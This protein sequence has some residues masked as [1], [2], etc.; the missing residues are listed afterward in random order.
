MALDQEA[1]EE[2]GSPSM[3]D[4]LRGEYHLLVGR[5]IAKIEVSEGEDQLRFTL[6]D[7]EH[8][9]WITGGTCCSESWF[10]DL[11]G[12]EALLRGTVTSVEKLE[13]EEVDDDRTRQKHD[14]VY[15]F[16]VT[17]NKGRASIAFRNSS[18]GWYCG[19]MDEEAGVG[20][21]DITWRVIEADWS[22]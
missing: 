6:S 22:A 12:V 14:L 9:L 18:N 5:T 20:A 11:T 4:E 2:K 21:D 16:K 7:H 1:Y 10:A 3:A 17:T 15:G 19:S 8:I 13:V